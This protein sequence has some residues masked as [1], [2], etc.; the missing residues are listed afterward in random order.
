MNNNFPFSDVKSLGKRIQVDSTGMFNMLGWALTS[1]AQ[2]VV[3][4]PAKQKVSGLIPNQGI[5]LGCGFGSWP[6]SL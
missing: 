6:G 1:V 5:C 3:C 2:L 4:R